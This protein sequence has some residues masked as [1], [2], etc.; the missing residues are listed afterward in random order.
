MT[1][2]AEQFINLN[3]VD[4][5]PKKS[6]SF[7]FAG[8]YIPPLVISSSEDSGIETIFISVLLSWSLLDILKK[9]SS[10]LETTER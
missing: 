8:Y 3:S 5:P 7:N 10:I 9:K 1:I 4:F 6:I 2:T